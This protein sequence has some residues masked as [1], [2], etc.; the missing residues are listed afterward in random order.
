MTEISE[1]YVGKSLLVKRFK[2]I[3]TTTNDGA[4]RDSGKLRLLKQFVK[5]LCRVVSEPC[6][7]CCRSHEEFGTKKGEHDVLFDLLKIPTI[8]V[9]PA[10]TPPILSS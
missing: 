5:P 8:Y 7:Q 10:P 6:T 9:Y 1:I 3:R 2:I 4:D